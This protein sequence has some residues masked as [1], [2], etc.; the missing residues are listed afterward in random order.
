MK[1][2]PGEPCTRF[3]GKVQGG[4]ARSGPAAMAARTALLV[5]LAL[6]ALAAPGA[7]AFS[8]TVCAFVSGQGGCQ[9]LSNTLPVAPLF[10]D[11]VS[12]PAGEV[13]IAVGACVP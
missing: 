11:S 7:E 1:V 10:C 2:L 6:V 5:A 9:T 12:Y 3:P 8:V 13:Y 4:E